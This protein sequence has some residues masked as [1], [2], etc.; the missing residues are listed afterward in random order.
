[1]T[2]R[3]LLRSRLSTRG[4][5]HRISFQTFIATKA[6]RGITEEQRAEFGRLVDDT[7]RRIESARVLPHS[8]VRFPQNACTSCPYVGLCL[9]QQ[10]LV[11]GTLVRRP[12]D[13][14]ALFDELTY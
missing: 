4:V 8:G 5:L 6:G 7:I 9:R 2:T 12:G 11:E 3:R 10:E 14:L 1:M 13:D